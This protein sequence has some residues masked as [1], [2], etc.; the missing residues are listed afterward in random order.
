MKGSTTSAEI[1]EAIC[2]LYKDGHSS[3]QLAKKFQ[4]SAATICAILES[5][6]IPRIYQHRSPYRLGNPRFFK[7]IDSE[8]KAYWLGF[9][10]A[11]G[12]IN[13]ERNK[14]VLR[15]HTKDRKHISRLLGALDSTHPITRRHFTAKDGITRDSCGISIGNPGLAEDL[16]SYPGMGGRKSFNLRWPT[17]LLGELTRDYIRGYMDGDGGFY[18]QPRKNRPSLHFTFEVV[19]NRDFL[20]ELQRRLAMHCNLNTTKIYPASNYT[21]AGKVVY[22]GRTQV[23]RIFNFLYKDATVWLPRKRDKIAPFMRD[24]YC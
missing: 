13:P 14:L 4:K 5:H 18:V 15:L 24:T 11:D 12:H 1:Q 9:I 20:V 23:K 10:A 17:A 16:M 2:Q 19:S 3:I 22:G 6:E 7:E 21:D 8:P